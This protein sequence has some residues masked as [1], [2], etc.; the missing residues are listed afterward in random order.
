MIEKETVVETETT[1]R[2]TQTEPIALSTDTRTQELVKEPSAEPEGTLL[3]DPKGVEKDEKEKPEEEKKEED[4]PDEKPVVYEDFKL[5]EGFSLEKEDADGFKTLAAEMKL[6]QEQ[7]QKLVDFE[8]S[9]M[10]KFVDKSQD[11]YIQTVEKWKTETL[12]KLD[13]KPNTTRA[14]QLGLAHKAVERF[15]TPELKKLLEMP[16]KDGSGGFGWGNLAPFLETMINV[17][18]AFGN[19]KLVDGPHGGADAP[20]TAGEVIFPTMAK[21]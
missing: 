3:D 11:G 10:Q 5:P 14:E 16:K 4:N 15:A 2:E 17:E 21:N 1:A 12:A 20:K 7:A 8:S 6:T 9:K 13:A 18:K 19:D